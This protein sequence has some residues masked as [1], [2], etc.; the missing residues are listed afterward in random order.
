M[1]LL[2]LIAAFVAGTVA[3]KVNF[4]T[5]VGYLAAGVALS[6]MGVQSNDELKAIGDLGVVL[7]LFTV[8]LHINFRSLLQIEV[9]GVGAAHL[10]FSTAMFGLALA[11][12]QLP[13]YATCP[14]PHKGNV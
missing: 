13:I 11:F 9:F 2:W 4:P 7:L 14:Y 3:K 6:I 5:L 1:T 8:G 10:I 12:W